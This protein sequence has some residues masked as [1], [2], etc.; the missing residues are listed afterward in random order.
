MA[1]IKGSAPM[2][3]RNY[4]LEHCLISLSLPGFLV[5]EA[6]LDEQ[7]LLCLNIGSSSLLV[8]HILEG[9]SRGLTWC[10]QV[11]GHLIEDWVLLL[12]LFPVSD[13]GCGEPCWPSHYCLTL[14]CFLAVQD[15]SDSL[16]SPLFKRG[17]GIVEYSLNLRVWDLVQVLLNLLLG[18]AFIHLA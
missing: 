14:D 5:Q 4:K 2:S 9:C 10:P 17:D 7:V 8:Q 15:G 13:V 11:L 1:T 3:L 6:I 16:L 18:E 12:L